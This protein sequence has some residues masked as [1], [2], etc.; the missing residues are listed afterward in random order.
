MLDPTHPVTAFFDHD[1]E[2]V[3]ASLPGLEQSSGAVTSFDT[4]ERQGE[5]LRGMRDGLFSPAIFGAPDSFGH[6]VTAPIVHP[7]VLEALSGILGYETADWIA[8]AEHRVAVRGDAL[9]REARDF[10]DD[11]LVGAA[12]IAEALRRERPDSPLLRL[13]S[14][15]K[16]PVPP[17]AARPTVRLPLPEAIDDWIGPVNEAYL[18]LIERAARAL[19]IVELDA[20]AIIVWSEL[21]L[22]QHAF[23]EACRRVRRADARLVPALRAPASTE[24][25]VLELAFA[26]AE[27]LVVQRTDAILVVDTAGRE[28][29]RHPPSGCT[30]RGVFDDRYAVFQGFESEAQPYSRGDD[31]E[32]IWAPEFLDRGTQNL[33][34]AISVIDLETGTYLE[35]LPPSVPHTFVENDEPED[36][37]IGERRLFVGGDRPGATAYRAGLRFAK[38]SGESSEIIDMR[39][40]LTVLVPPTVYPDEV[41]E[42]LDLASGEVVEHDWDDQG[43]GWGEAIGFADG[44]WF[45]VSDYGILHDHGGAE[46]L[47]LVPVPRTVAFDGACQRLAVAHGG[48][49]IV[50]VDRAART[51]VA[52][53]TLTPPSE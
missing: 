4:R 21:G 18:V 25:G 3:L 14:L 48:D 47:A 16:V 50:I 33:V 34:G 51:V 45:L 15:T 24:E 11:D 26:G 12:G 53:I 17:L 27:R 42:A 10:E 38:V 46:Q 39:T 20:P 6:I 30:L 7:C 35:Q 22:L 23:A 9:V 37:F 28:L 19:R 29:A 43:G 52:R 13:C 32:Q 5:S 44:R 40:G 8:I 2:R 1:P 41:K 31:T 49:D 36:L